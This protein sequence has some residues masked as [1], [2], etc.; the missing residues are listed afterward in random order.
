MP[1]ASRGAPRYAHLLLVNSRAARSVSRCVYLLFA[2][3][4]PF[5]PILLPLH[6]VFLMRYC[7]AAAAVTCLPST[8]CCAP[9]LNALVLALCR[10]RSYCRVA[11]CL[12]NVPYLTGSHAARNNALLT[13]PPFYTMTMRRRVYGSV[14]YCG[15]NDA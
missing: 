15:A 6:T 8:S 12:N 4:L 14:L 13:H 1:H 9:P 10:L 3:C 5:S 7:A 11:Y 2:R